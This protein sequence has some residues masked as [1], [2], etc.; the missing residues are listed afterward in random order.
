MKPRVNII[1][2]KE[3]LCLRGTDDSS[4]VVKGVAE[5]TFG[6]PGTWRLAH[7]VDH[8]CDWYQNYKPDLLVKSGMVD[9]GTHVTCTLNM[10]RRKWSRI[11]DRDISFAAVA[12]RVTPPDKKVV[13]AGFGHGVWAYACAAL[14][15]RTVIALDPSD[16]AHQSAHMLMSSFGSFDNI[17]FEAATLGE[18][19]GAL[20]DGD[21]LFLPSCGFLEMELF[22]E[23]M[24]VMSN[25][26]LRAVFKIWFRPP[27]V[28]S[29]FLRSSA[30]AEF[31]GSL[32]VASASLAFLK[33]R[34]WGA[35][36][37]AEKK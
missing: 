37:Y 5:R 21:T 27:F 36:V 19:A 3:F 1:S 13:Y 12:G 23:F 16:L 7:I 32:G 4:F 29:H 34:S 25:A 2:M 33:W 11:L 8:Y 10:S 28:R 35:L 6:K 20:E 24:S 22:K 17:R 31:F 14:T 18:Y 15:G 26:R 9:E 30:I